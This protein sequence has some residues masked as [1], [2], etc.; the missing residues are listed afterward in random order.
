MTDIR[1]QASVTLA[2]ALALSIVLSALVAGAV[3]QTGTTTDFN[4]NENSNDG[5][6]TPEPTP[7]STPEPTPEPTPDPGD[8]RAISFAALCVVAGDVDESDVV[9]ITFSNPKPGEPGEFLTASFNTTVPVDYVVLK[10]ATTAEE[11]AFDL[12]GVTSGS[13]TVGDG[14]AVDRP[15]NDPCRAGDAGVKKEVDDGAFEAV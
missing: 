14:V 15:A 6:L 13:A 3:T 9:D 10:Y 4:L 2:A 12:G 11:F 8:Q 5:V 1:G 7:E